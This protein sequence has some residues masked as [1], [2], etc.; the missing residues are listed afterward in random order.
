M[1]TVGVD[2][3]EA[4][5]RE[6]KYYSIGFGRTWRIRASFT[7]TRPKMI[8]MVPVIKKFKATSTDSVYICSG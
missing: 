2:V 7:G 1:E 8:K 3:Y 6:F 5:R 4:H